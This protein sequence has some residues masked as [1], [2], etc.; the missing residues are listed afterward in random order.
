MSFFDRLMRALNTGSQG[1]E[2]PTPLPPAEKTKT[3]RQPRKPKQELSAKD[4]A[5]QRG[6]PYVTI[7]KFDLDPEDLRS[8]AFELDWNDKFIANLIRAGYQM[9]PDDTDSELVDRWFQNVCRNV[10]LETWEQEQANNPA[11]WVKSKDIGNGRR[12]VS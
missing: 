7:L 8:G 11:R 3:Q 5:T 1:V 9:K 2:H 12:E 4:L 10:V 6:E